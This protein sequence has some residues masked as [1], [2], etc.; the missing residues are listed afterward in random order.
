[1]GEYQKEK[2]GTVFS[3]PKH[4]RDLFAVMI[5]TTKLIDLLKGSLIKNDHDAERRMLMSAFD[6][7]QRSEV[8]DLEGGDGPC[9]V[10][11]IAAELDTETNFVADPVKQFIVDVATTLGL[12]CKGVLTDSHRHLST[13]IAKKV[14]NF[15]EMACEFP[16]ESIIQPKICHAVEE[17]MLNSLGLGEKEIA[18]TVREAC[19]KHW[20]YV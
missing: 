1:M 4:E 18:Q 2:G 16:K 20:M 9:E 5:A 8:L 10:N 13:P 12:S 19:R 15:L 17:T 3:P 11:L 6:L 14:V 7:V